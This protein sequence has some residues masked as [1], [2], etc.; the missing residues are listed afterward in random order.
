MSKSNQIY[1]ILKLENLTAKEVSKKLNFNKGTT[2]SYISTLKKEGK[3]EVVGKKGKANVYSSIVD[4]K[5]LDEIPIQKTS[6]NLVDHPKFIDS[7]IFSFI[8]SSQN[9]SF[10]K[11][12]NFF[13]TLGVLEKNL[14]FALLRNLDKELL[15][16]EKVPDGDYSRILNYIIKNADDL[17][18]KYPLTMD[19]QE[20]FSIFR[21]LGFRD[22]KEFVNLI[23]KLSNKY[24][25][26]ISLSSSR[27]GHLPD[28]LTIKQIFIHPIEFKLTGAWSVE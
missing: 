5:K 25:E 6:F 19:F 17:A 28:L 10:S 15:R 18:T 24:P 4:K 2:S 16:M 11:I 21:S 9:P 1:E 20:A 8:S 14:V 27:T 13:S 12:Q 26:F 23:N 22:I 7:L 3:L